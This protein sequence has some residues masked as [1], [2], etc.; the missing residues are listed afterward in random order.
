M[1]VWNSNQP[2]LTCILRHPGTRIP[3]FSKA[4]GWSSSRIAEVADRPNPTARWVRGRSGDTAVASDGRRSWHSWERLPARSHRGDMRV[5]CLLLGGALNETYTNS[6]YMCQVSTRVH[7]FAVFIFCAWCASSPM[8]NLKPEVGKWDMPHFRLGDVGFT[9][10]VGYSVHSLK[11]KLYE[12]RI[13]FL[14]AAL[15]VCVQLR[16][17]GAEYI[18]TE[19]HHV[20]EHHYPVSIFGIS[21]IWATKTLRYFDNPCDMS[22]ALIL[23]SCGWPGSIQVTHQG[24]VTT[25]WQG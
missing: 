20:K 16:S 24:N 7:A 23:Q 2:S 14:N 9:C 21:P 3:V 13:T 15:C 25:S 6:W 11:S 4:P 1:E 18:N 5:I 19:M 12:F 22:E 10:N 8:A 17:A